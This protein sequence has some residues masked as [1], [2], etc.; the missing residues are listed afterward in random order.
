[1]GR[2]DGNRCPDPARQAGGA[3]AEPTAGDAASS[4]D[5]DVAPGGADRPPSTRV[6]VVAGVA[7]LLMVVAGLAAAGPDAGAFMVA[8]MLGSSLVGAAIA[9]AAAP[10]TGWLS[11]LQARVLLAARSRNEKRLESLSDL[12]WQIVDQVARYRDLLDEIDAAVCRRDAA[13]RITFVNR[14]FCQ[15]F[16]V[17][18]ARV[19]G[20]TF[21][22][23]RASLGP[24][25]LP[26]LGQPCR[27]VCEVSTASGPRWLSIAE[28][29]VPPAAGAQG[30]EWQ[31]V[32]R[33]VTEEVARDREVGRA[34]AL[35]EEA[36]RAKSRFLAAVSHEIRTPMNG[37]IGMAGLLGETHLTA[38]Q[39]T[40][41]RTISQ[42]ARSLLQLIDDVLDFSRL[43]ARRLTV[44]RAPFE[45]EQLVQDVVELLAPRA[46]EKDL[47]L[48]WSIDRS[49][50]REFLGDGARVRQILLNLLGNAIKFTDRGGVWVT[51]GP[52]AGRETAARPG[53][54]GVLAIDVRDTGIG[55]APEALQRIFGEFEQFG[56]GAEHRGG[57]GL[58]LA[59]SQAL[60]R[61][62]G[63]DISVVSQPRRGSVFTLELPL[64]AVDQPPNPDVAREAAAAMP[65]VLLMF[66]GLIERRG[67]A[68]QLAAAG[69]GVREADTMEGPSI[70][71]SARAAGKP[72]DIVLV[73]AMDG[74]A[75]LDGLLAGTATRG[76]VVMSPGARPDL[77]A[78]R[79]VGFTEFLV[80]P[81]RPRSLEARLRSAG[82]FD[83]SVDP[84]DCGALPARE[85]PKS[86][87]AVVAPRSPLRVMIVE[88]NAVNAL[89]TQRTL[90]RMGCEIVTAR[91]GEAAVTY[92]R[93][94]Y[95]GQC[96]PVD[97]ILMD[98]HMPRLSGIEATARI[99]EL[100]GV[101]GVQGP[102][103]R[104][105]IIAVTASAF[106][107]DRRR[108]LAAGMDDYLAK[109]FGPAELERCIGRWT[110]ATQVEASASGPAA[111]GGM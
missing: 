52:R 100:T 27:T 43:E 13:G 102:C 110:T 39:Q 47:E 62:M 50:P 89:L 80:R 16:G 51:V 103:G 9:I 82:P 73:D 92:M 61:A 69:A 91:D 17:E 11:S 105:V 42:S 7:G 76:I 86:V 49:L 101:T 97:V 87:A 41:T 56:A 70:L 12:E 78:H 68:A 75:E 31:L 21:D 46:F 14:S 111:P 106:E 4:G 72:F 55:L 84:H 33:D 83:D 44:E 88:D 34:K 26:P 29:Q 99:R 40:Y 85:E 60:A 48:V 67:L 30:V 79:D 45:L 81:V 57:T 35:A 20:T 32:G 54:T 66:D 8:L 22:P 1:M 109:P 36:S 95:A 15:L 107:E 10:S 2:I 63:G 71:R 96:E 98:M 19:L 65:G 93:R 37:I 74:T 53:E 28:H 5:R 3:D 18:S 59:I 77:K 64:V 108:C 104:P 25:P 38:E 90:E 58:G 94:M 24:T 23:V 6:A